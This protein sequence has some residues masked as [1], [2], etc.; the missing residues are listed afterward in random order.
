MFTVYVMDQ[1]NVSIR[2]YN[3]ALY[4]SYEEKS[5]VIV[6]FEIKLQYV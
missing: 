1:L 5:E 3:K 6:S 4:Q 2:T